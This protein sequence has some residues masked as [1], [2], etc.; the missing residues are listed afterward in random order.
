M[1]QV[2]GLRFKLVYPHWYRN[3]G[4]QFPF[5]NG[6]LT[7]TVSWMR[8]MLNHMN[9]PIN[10]DDLDRAQCLSTFYK[11]TE[12]CYIFRHADLYRH[13]KL[14]NQ[15]SA[16][17]LDN[18]KS[19][20]PNVKY[21]YPIEIECGRSRFLIE[22]HFYKDNHKLETYRF[23]NTIP[24]PVLDFIRNGKIKL[25][26]SNMVD[27]CER[28]DFLLEFEKEMNSIGIPSENIV[29]LSGNIDHEYQGKMQQVSS[30]ISLYQ[31]S[32]TIPLYPFETSLGYISDYVKESDIDFNK[33]RSKK[34]LSFNR[35]LAGAHRIAWCIAAIEQDLLKDG[36]FSFLT[37]LNDNPGHLQTILDQSNLSIL[38]SQISKIKNLIPYELD[39]QHL[40]NKLSFTTNENNKK[41][42]Y[43]DSYFHITSE[44]EF[45]SQRTPFFSE[46]TWRPMLNLQPFVYF[47]N[48]FSLKELRDMGFYTFEPFID[49]S[50]DQEIDVKKR[51]ALIIEEIKKLNSLSY[52]EL[53]N[54][55]SCLFDRVKHNQETLNK[56]IGYNP[57]IKL[58]EK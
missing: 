12:F 27:P 34:F 8:D 46:K 9:S 35:N 5:P 17:S 51:F 7:Q 32:H 22:D 58:L 25:L 26:I 49:E 18:V 15:H 29:L 55:Y 13:F 50:Y 11:N 6:L 56:K 21:F 54:L 23:K 47:G 14:L 41:E 28:L 30:I 44:T 39:T 53:H 1:E 10:L 3:K 31:T 45:T 20:P 24:D 43:L 37:N 40:E 19:F 38:E 2:S 48:P 57:L 52:E 4:I 16:V 36:Y 42:F 33:K